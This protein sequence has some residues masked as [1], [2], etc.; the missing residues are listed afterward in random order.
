MTTSAPDLIVLHEHPEWQKPLFAALE[1]RGVSFCSVRRHAGGVQQ[2]RAA[3]RLPLLQ[4]G[5]SKRVPARSHAGGS[6]GTRLHAIAGAARRPGAERRRRVRARA[7]QE[8]PGDAAAHARHR[9]PALDHVQRRQRASRATR[10]TCRGRPCS[11]P[12]RAAAV[13]AS[14]WSSRW[15]RSKRSSA[16]IRRCG[17][18]TICS[19]CRNTCR[20]TPS[21]VS[22]ASSF[23][24][25]SSS[26]RCGSR[27]TGASTCARRRSAIR[28]K[29]PA[30]CAVPADPGVDAAPVEFFPFLDVPQRSRRHRETDRAGGQARR[31][32]YRVS[33]HVRWP[34]GLLRHQRELEPAPVG[35]RG[36]RLRSVR[37]GRRFSREQSAATPTPPGSGEKL[38]RY[39]TVFDATDRVTFVVMIQSRDRRHRDIASFT[40]A[41]Q[42]H[43]RAAGSG[44]ARRVEKRTIRRPMGRYPFAAALNDWPRTR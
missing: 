16:A 35:R 2:R 26:M 9:L 36:V 32:R 43:R 6:A 11:S 24:V 13:R 17:C 10:A 15:R 40:S 28:T 39:C 31:R 41:R 44:G 21:R 4:P 3:P 38:Y 19:C 37:A 7:E 1:R 22:S 18:R 8:R 30:L 25:A 23:S 20:T 33:G 14:R 34:A 5:E 42:R 29:A 27:R 12:T